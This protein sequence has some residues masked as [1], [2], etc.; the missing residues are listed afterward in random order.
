MGQVLLHPRFPQDELDRWKAQQRSQLVQMRATPAFLGLERLRQALYGGDAR[1]IV[2]GFALS[3]EWVNGVLSQ[4]MQAREYGLAEDYWDTYP[5][6][7]MAVTA[8][9]VQRVARKYVPLENVQLIAVG[10]GSKIA[11]VLSKYGPP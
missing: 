4:R 1:A 8:A 11:E 5:E 3:L 2:A 7:V 6:K 10:D 9:E